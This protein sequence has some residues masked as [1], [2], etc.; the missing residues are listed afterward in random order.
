M[1]VA[2]RSKHGRQLIT[3]MRAD[4]ITDDVVRSPPGGFPK[5][6]PKLLHHHGGAVVLKMRNTHQLMSFLITTSSACASPRS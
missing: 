6:E 4:L 2:V 5:T 3:M 1:V